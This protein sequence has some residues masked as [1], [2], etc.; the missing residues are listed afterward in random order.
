MPPGPGSLLLSRRCSAAAS[1]SLT[2][3]QS[4][5]ISIPCAALACMRSLPSTHS[6]HLAAAPSDRSLSWSLPDQLPLPPQM[7]QAA[8]D[9]G[10]DEIGDS[11]MAFLVDS[12]S[13]F[14]SVLPPVS[15]DLSLLLARCQRLAP[16]RHLI[17]EAMPWQCLKNTANIQHSVYRA[18]NIIPI[19]NCL[20]GN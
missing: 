15:L 12:L 11:C 18:K 2:Q 8:P 14:S 5:R 10:G 7:S 16:C 4:G 19:I 9:F 3:V 17:A 6:L 20:N 1:P 13:F